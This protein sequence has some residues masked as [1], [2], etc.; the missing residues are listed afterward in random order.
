MRGDH[1]IVGTLGTQQKSN[2]RKHQPKA[3]SSMG[4]PLSWDRRERGHDEEKEP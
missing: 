1:E 3:T 4:L 2:K